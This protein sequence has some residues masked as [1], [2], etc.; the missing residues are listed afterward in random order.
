MIRAVLLLLL[1]TV[2]ACGGSSQTTP[3]TPTPP[4]TPAAT[5][6]LVNVDAQGVILGGHD[7]VTYQSD[8]KATPGTAAHASQHDGATYQFASA[9]HKTAF[10]PAKHAPRY[11]GYCA[12][13]ASMN[14][15]SESDPTVFQIV[16]GQLLVFT[17]EDFKQKF[18]ADVAGNKAKADANWPGL[19]EQHGK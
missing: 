12:F 18:N 13:A 11:G 2:A 3:T 15:L 4:T 10:D 16:D 7:P 17:N 14:R 19:V 1:S 9:E 6:R 5:K 8:N